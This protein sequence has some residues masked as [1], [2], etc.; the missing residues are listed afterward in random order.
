MITDGQTKL[1]FDDS[2]CLPVQPLAEHLN[3]GMPEQGLHEV[4]GIYGLYYSRDFLDDDEQCEA[5]KHIDTEHWSEDLKRRVQHY[6]WR[7][8]YQTRTITSDMYLGPLPDWITKLAER[9][10]AETGLFDRIPEQVIVNE[11]K[12]GQ[13]IALHADKDCFGPTVAT[14]S[15]GDDW[16]MKFRPVK[17]SSD[18]DTS[19]MLQRGS[20]LI[21]TDDARFQWMH[22]I[23]K[24]KIERDKSSQRKRRRRVSLTFRTVI[25]QTS[26]ARL[27]D[28]DTV[29]T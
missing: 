6:G 26:G 23:D 3:Y 28:Y 12:P 8:D 22:G 20:A 13:G 10:Y 1:M 18:E 17:G 16:E 4:P 25:N 15:L 2:A 29:T 5:V 7:Y 11:Y 27:A 9:L 14:I 19:I 21:L 24:R